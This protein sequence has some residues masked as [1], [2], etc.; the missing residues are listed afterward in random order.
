MVRSNSGTPTLRSTSATVR[1]SDDL[2]QVQPLGGRGEP[3]G[4]GHLD[5]GPELLH[6]QIHAHDA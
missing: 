1:L 5:H 2:G 3:A 4:V 6:R